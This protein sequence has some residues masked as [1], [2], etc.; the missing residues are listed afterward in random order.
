MNNLYDTNPETER[1]WLQK[2]SHMTVVGDYL[3]RTP[4]IELFHPQNGECILDAGCGTGDWTAALLKKDVRLFGCDSSEKMLG[5]A[6]GEEKRKALGIQYAQTDITKSLPYRNA[7]FDGIHCVAVLI[8]ICPAG[9]ESFLS[10][11]YRVLKQ[12]GRVLLSTMHPA[13]YQ[14]N[15]PNRTA[16]ASWAQYTPL[17]SRP[18][19]ESQPFQETYHD[20]HGQVFI[21][22][23]WYHPEGT[24][25]TLLK[26]SG[27]TIQKVQDMYMTR[28]VLEACN[29]TGAINYPCFQQI[30]ALKD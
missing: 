6:I 30:L 18:L 7:Q 9:C 21:S 8:H 28:A 12:N 25:L 14:E 1:F 24:L 2:S 20:A 13:L 4:S 23:V 10:E 19:S 5:R 17:T 11:A 26:K 22:T 15:S 3:G 29:Q 16:R 27:F